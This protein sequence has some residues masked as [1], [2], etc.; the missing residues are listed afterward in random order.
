MYRLKIV[1]LL[2]LCILQS[3]ISQ[4]V[5]EV[6][7]TG[8][9]IQ[10]DGFLLEWKPSL[11]KSFGDN[12]EFVCDA[13]KTPEG[14][15]GYCKSKNPVSCGDWTITVSNELNSEEIVKIRCLRSGIGE[16]SSYYQ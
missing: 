2:V 4:V 9:R 3:I 10:L 1:T 12:I 8:R 6:K 7:D 16:K 14:L 11:A 15:S 5:Y 13:F